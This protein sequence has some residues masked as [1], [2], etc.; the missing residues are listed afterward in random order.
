MSASHR[1]RYSAHRNVKGRNFMCNSPEAKHVSVVGDFNKWNSRS[2]PMQQGSDGIWTTRIDLRHGHHR[3]AFEVDGD[4]VLDP[5]A[6]G[7]TRDDKGSRVSL[8][9]VS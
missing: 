7:I 2:D 1:H 4:F 3:Y 8:I 5:T 9:A 6:M